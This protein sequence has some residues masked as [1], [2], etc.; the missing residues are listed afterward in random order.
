MSVCG[1]QRGDKRSRHD[2]TVS[3]GMAKV[4]IFQDDMVDTSTE[5][6]V[7]RDAD[8]S[9]DSCHTYHPVK[10][11][12]SATHSAS[13]LDA[14]PKPSAVRIRFQGTQMSSPGEFNSLRTT[15]R[16]S[17]HSTD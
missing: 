17:C 10:Y 1:G 3:G 12:L 2:T 16:R 5:W 7:G 8:V 14:R 11:S 4:R 9:I 13:S 6:A 15:F